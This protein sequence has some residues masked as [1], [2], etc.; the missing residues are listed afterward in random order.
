MV[1]AQA[2]VAVWLWLAVHGGC[3]G[4]TYEQL[5]GPFVSLEQCEQHAARLTAHRGPPSPGSRYICK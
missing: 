1:I 4:N 3:G 2:A 5:A